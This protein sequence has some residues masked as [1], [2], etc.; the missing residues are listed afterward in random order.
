MIHRNWWS[1][2]CLGL[3]IFL[4]GPVQ[5]KSYLKKADYQGEWILPMERLP[6]DLIMFPTLT[7]ANANRSWEFSSNWSQVISYPTWS[8]T[9]NP[10]LHFPINVPLGVHKLAHCNIVTVRINQIQ[11]IGTKSLL[12]IY[13]HLR[14]SSFNQY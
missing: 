2:F 14:P 9:E 5:W 12:M 10:S 11:L 3:D 13:P 7:H 8:V 1:M 4:I 6:P